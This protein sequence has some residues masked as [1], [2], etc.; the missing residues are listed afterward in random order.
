MSDDDQPIQPGEEREA[1]LRRISTEMAAIQKNAFGKGPIG[2]K[3][4][5]FDD[6]L[7]IVMR[8]GLTVAEK[9]MLGFDR[10]DLV[11]QFRQEFE[12][13]MKTRIVDMVEELIDRKVLTYQSQIMFDP[14]V[15]VE[16]FVFDRATDGGFVAAEIR[17]E[18]DHA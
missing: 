15:I 14:D 2:A 12:N 13:E 3:S 7:L 11:R 18:P 17:E 1:L 6:L 5:L 16:L 8:E 9:T 4:Y 10:H